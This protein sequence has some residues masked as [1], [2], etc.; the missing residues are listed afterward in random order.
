[1]RRILHVGLGPLGRMIVKDLVERKLGEVVAAVDSAPAIAGKKLSEIVPAA[2]GKASVLSSLEEIRDW[3]SIDA[4][5]VTTSS[6]FAICAPT[7]REL[8]GRGVAIVSTCE[9]LVY[10]WYR[11][12]ALAR[13]L[14]V[15]A[16]ENRGRLLGTGVNPG[17]LMDAFPVAATAI[18]RSVE[19]V[20]VRRFQD[21]S[22][23][24]IPFQKKVGVGLD[25]AGFAAQ[26]KAGTLR[27]VG[28][29]ESVHFIASRLGIAIDRYEEEIHP[30]RAE[31]E[32]DSALGKIR[33][34]AI[35]GVRQVGRGYR[36]DSVAIL[37]EFIAAI[38]LEDPHDRV[39][40]HGEPEIDLTWRGGVHGDVATSAIVLNSIGPLL[41]SAPGLHTMATIPL[42]GCAAPHAAP[43]RATTR[44]R[45]APAPP[46]P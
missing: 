1:M 14:D 19:S 7:F 43:G 23:R 3:R 12:D 40:V 44:R 36:R 6:D 25:E 18:S 38:G 24:R 4:A 29:G 31:R 35:R 10:P 46:V 15:L 21:A 33:A 17:F 13:E 41:A 20:E 34:G 32:L 26:V 27:H 42:V 8:L 30:V 37:L 5:I 28:L 9:E 11:H 45:A 22:T 16:R 39:I 2:K